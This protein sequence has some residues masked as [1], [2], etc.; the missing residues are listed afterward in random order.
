M[1]DRDGLLLVN[2]KLFGADVDVWVEVDE[3]IGRGIRGYDEWAFDVLA[4]YLCEAEG[5]AQPDKIS[6]S[7]LTPEERDS[8]DQAVRLE[9]NEEYD[10]LRVS[11]YI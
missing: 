5:G 2:T 3:Y 10:D 9:L 11:A 1:R 7:R 4:V 6:L 8:L